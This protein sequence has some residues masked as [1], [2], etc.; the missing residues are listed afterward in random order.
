MDELSSSLKPEE[1][2]QLK[3]GEGIVK[4][5]DD[6]TGDFATNVMGTVVY[7]KG[8]NV[9]KKMNREYAIF[10]RDVFFQELYQNYLVACMRNDDRQRPF[11]GIITKWDMH[12]T[13]DD[14][15]SD[16]IANIDYQIQSTKMAKEAEAQKFRI[17]DDS[18]LSEMKIDEGSSEVGKRMTVEEYDAL[19]ELLRK[20]KETIEDYKAGRIQLIIDTQKGTT[21]VA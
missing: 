21:R 13:F 3:K 12:S 10:D 7:D 8:E 18:L 16:A 11:S 15:L 9:V 17:L 14:F 20:S 2:T 1:P 5:V 4:P 6:P 19:Y